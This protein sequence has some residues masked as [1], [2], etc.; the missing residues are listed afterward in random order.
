MILPFNA[1]RFVKYNL[2]FAQNS[3]CEQYEISNATWQFSTTSL[4][5]IGKLCNSSYV[6]LND[7]FED[8]IIATEQCDFSAINQLNQLASLLT[9]CNFE[10]VQH[11]KV[12]IR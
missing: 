4:R 11:S 6:G 3:N 8:F 10:I 5:T 7:R 1:S 2:E 9:M 12:I